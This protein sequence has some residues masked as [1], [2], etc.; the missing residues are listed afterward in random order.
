MVHNIKVRNIIN[1]EVVRLNEE[2][3]NYERVKNFVLC[4]E[5]WTSEK[6]EITATLKPV[7]QALL[8][9]YRKEIEKMYK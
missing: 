2:L 4:H 5:E 9:N 1:R 3:P 7:R 8:E 6:G